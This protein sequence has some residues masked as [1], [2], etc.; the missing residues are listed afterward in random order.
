MLPA[1]APVYLVNGVPR[2]RKVFSD[3]ALSMPKVESVDYLPR[4]FFANLA[5]W[6]RLPRHTRCLRGKPVLPRMNGIFLG[7][8]VFKIACGVIRLVSVN[9]VDNRTA[10]FGPD[11]RAGHQVCNLIRTLIPLSLTMKVREVD[12]SVSV[13][14]NNGAENPSLALCPPTVVGQ[15][16]AEAGRLVKALKARY[17]FPFFHSN[18]LSLKTLTVNQ[19]APRGYTTSRGFIF[20]P[21]LDIR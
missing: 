17:V 14:A 18:N 8:Y 15:Y 21:N 5:P 9:M 19:P 12:H 2:R 11:K 7:G 16:S 6:I 20:Q 4:T 13:L 1:S 10:R 3:V